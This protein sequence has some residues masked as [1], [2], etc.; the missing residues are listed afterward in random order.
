MQRS[1]G[2][3]SGNGHHP[4]D[5]D[6]FP[7]RILLGDMLT[8]LGHRSE[9]AGEMQSALQTFELAVKARPDDGL[10]WY[11]YGDALLALER[12]EEALEALARAVDIEPANEL[13]RYDLGL[14]LYNLARYEEAAQHFS[15]MVQA[16]PKLER[17]KSH[18]GLSGITNLA[19]CYGEQGNWREA[20]E[21]LKPARSMAVNI[22]YNLGRLHSRNGS[23]AEAAR[24]LE[25]AAILAPQD[26]Q[27]LHEAGYALRNLKRFEEAEAYLLRATKVRPFCVGA[28][29]DRGVNL[30]RMNKRRQA[31]SCF[32]QVLRRNPQH[33]WAYYG[34]ACLDALDRKRESAL[35]NLN[36]AIDRGLKDIDHVRKDRDL[37]SLHSDPRW[38]ELI[39]RMKALP[40]VR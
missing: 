34:L 12:T 6:G 31:R 36:R 37:A 13:Y 32:L 39:S 30:T 22:L 27:I 40:E 20:L 21:T 35:R 25:A 4:F 2:Q 5:Q 29:F 17:A 3:G 19:L 8:D 26:E 14:A 16:D 23:N 7:L 15:L 10:A 33:E 28:L 9:K 38:R 1:A 24:L 18:L 11:N